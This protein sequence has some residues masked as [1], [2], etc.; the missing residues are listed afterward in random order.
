MHACMH[1][2]NVDPYFSAH[3]PQGV[4]A[5]LTSHIVPGYRGTVSCGEHSH[6]SPPPCV[7][8]GTHRLAQRALGGLLHG[9]HDRLSVCCALQPR[10]RFDH[11]YCRHAWWMARGSELVASMEVRAQHAAGWERSSQSAHELEVPFHQEHPPRV[12]SYT[13]VFCNHFRIL[14][15]L[16][17]TAQLCVAGMHNSHFDRQ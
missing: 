6:S 8:T 9:R 13:W 15:V 7:A 3:F 1:L 2:G 17:T 11:H 16:G 10:C 4:A 14:C 12:R 5:A